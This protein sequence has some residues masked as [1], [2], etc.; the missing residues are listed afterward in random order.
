MN[1]LV[2]HIISFYLKWIDLMKSFILQRIKIQELLKQATLLIWKL[3]IFPMWPL[4]LN[5]LVSFGNHIKPTLKP[6]PV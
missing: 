1:P 5:L 4:L 3:F 6:L 2:A